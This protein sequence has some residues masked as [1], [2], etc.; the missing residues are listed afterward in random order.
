MRSTKTLGLCAGLAA[1]L[2]ATAG[3][4]QT[5]D[6]NA[7]RRQNAVLD[8]ERV[9]AHPRLFGGD[10]G[11]IALDLLLGL[12]RQVDSPY[13]LDALR[14]IN[15]L[16]AVQSG[17]FDAPDVLPRLLALAERSTDA[18][19]ELLI[20]ELAIGVARR[21]RFAERA[22]AL[23]PD[24][25]D[26]FVTDW[27]TLGPLGPP[28]PDVLPLVP[29]I[30]GSPEVLGRER[31]YGESYA[32]TMVLAGEDGA[33]L[34]WLS[35]RRDTHSARV[36]A[37]RSVWPRAGFVYALCYLR[38]PEASDSGASVERVLEVTSDDA[39]R[40][41]WNGDLCHDAAKIE[42]TDVGPT[43]RV[44]VEVAPGWNALLVRLSAEDAPRVGARLLTTS[45]A[46]TPF[47]ELVPAGEHPVLPETR[48][49]DR[50]LDPRTLAVD[51]AT[52]GPHAAALSV[53]RRTYAQRPDEAL[54]VDAPASEDADALSGWWSARAFALGR[55]RHLDGEV[56]R[57]ALLFALERLEAEAV[58]RDDTWLR[59]IALQSAEDRPLEALATVDRWIAAAPDSVLA[60]R[61]RVQVLQTVDTT[62]T[63]AAEAAREAL[64]AHPDLDSARRVLADWLDRDGDRAGAV[65]ETFELLVRTGDLGLVGA[66]LGRLEGADDPRVE[67]LLE[68]VRAERKVFDTDA[69]LVDAELSLLEHLDRTPERLAL[70]AERAAA[71]PA[72]PGRWWELGSAR[73]E[74]G[75]VDGAQEA[76]RRELALRPA[77]GT[78]RE[79]LAELGAEDPAERFFAAFAP[80]RDAALAR[81]RASADASVVEALDSGLVY[82]FPDGSS[83][84][85]NSSIAFATDRAGV[86][87]LSALP[88]RDEPRVVRV[89][90]TDGSVLEPTDAGGEW[91]LP[92]LE[93]GDVVELVWDQRLDAP[94]PG[95]VP[96][97]HTWRFASFE[98]AFPTS[99]WAVFVPEGLARGRVKALQF[100]GD[101]EAIP[102]E[103]GTVHLYDSSLPRQVPEPAMPDYPRVL[104]IAAFGDD[105]GRGDD[106]RGYRAFVAVESHLPADIARETDA[107]VAEVRARQEEPGDA[108][109]ARALYEAVDARSRQFEGDSGAA[110]VWQ[111]Q[112]GWPLFLYGALLGREGVPFEWA[113]LETGVSPEL[114]RFPG[115][116]FEGDYALNGVVLRLGRLDG[117]DGAEPVWVLPGQAPGTP[118]GELPNR[119]AGARVFVLEDEGGVR[120]EFLPRRY[121]DERWDADITLEYAV[122]VDGAARVRGRFQ[123]AGPEGVMALGQVRQATAQQRDAFALSQAATL[124]PGIDVERAEVVLDGSRG[125]GIV[126][127]FEGVRPAFAA[128]A[129]D[130]TRRAALPFLAMG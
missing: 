44:R 83:H 40:A 117:A 41:Y 18:T 71:L 101:Y 12:E 54:T 81:A 26:E 53:L 63:L 64:A 120:E 31:R 1:T 47:D 5:A 102:F 24:L 72:Q 100:E 43:R 78:T 15:R 14:R 123:N 85:R 93:V 7:G 89:E 22:P 6:P 79:L 84:S 65:D 57:R 128:P 127:E 118:F 39:F 77:D 95:A 110:S 16:S 90:K 82:V 2:L 3:K 11:E 99:R 106:W 109:F 25:R 50:V 58:P 96:T 70:L 103:G 61:A 108:A 37:A 119:A 56:A 112:R 29:P 91:V 48:V 124:A 46:N 21:G 60:L 130:G 86:E 67:F 49:W 28:D 4:A 75:D 59:R 19:T 76:L 13:A 42:P 38:D 32:A 115:T 34:E 114:Q 104:P 105:E 121:L 68:R 51:E 36:A 80:D 20:E 23:P 10:P 122:G 17:A 30:A 27:L 66:F 126:V 113:V 116:I 69:R 73:L 55:A 45:S 111:T 35:A 88:L 98:R 125:P 62:G 74:R 94:A 92:T 8:A 87:A 129:D 33:R 97:Q 52:A 107:F 9:T